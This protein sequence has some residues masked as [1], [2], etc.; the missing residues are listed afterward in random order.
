MTLD[1]RFTEWATPAEAA[2]IG[3]GSPTQMVAGPDGALWF[4]A[5]SGNRIGLIVCGS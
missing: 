1:G 5:P 3:H 4:A 2:G